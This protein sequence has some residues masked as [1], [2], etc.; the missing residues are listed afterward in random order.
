MHLFSMDIESKMY[1]ALHKS[2]NTIG[3]RYL[4]PRLIFIA[5]DL[6]S[7]EIEITCREMITNQVP[8]DGKVSKAS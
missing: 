4:V 5:T 8:F 3:L 1:G 6:Y 2:S 7:G